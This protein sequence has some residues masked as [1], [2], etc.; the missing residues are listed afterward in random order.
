VAQIVTDINAYITVDAD[1]QTTFNI[2]QFMIA[3]ATRLAAIPDPG[4]NYAYNTPELLR[5]VNV[6]PFADKLLADLKGIAE[7]NVGTKDI[8]ALLLDLEA[9]AAAVTK[10]YDA[11]Y[12]EKSA[13][14]AIASLSSGPIHKNMPDAEDTTKETRYYRTTFVDDW[15]VESAPSEV[16]AAVEVGPKDTVTVTVGTVPTGRDITH[17]R[18]Y[19]SNS[20]NETA[21]FQ[22][23][24][25]P[26]DDNG[27][28]IAS[29][30]VT[31]NVKNSALQEICPTTIWD[32][33]PT[34]LQGLV[35]MANGIHL[36][37]FGNTLCPSI[38]YK[39][40]AYPEDYR[41]TV[42]WPIVGLAAWGQSAFVGTRGKPY[43]VHGTDA[44]SL[45][46]EVLDS[47]QACVSARSICATE[48]GVVYASPDGLCLATPVGVEVIT[49]GHFTREEWQALGP[50]NLIAREHDGS[51]YMVLPNTVL[52]ASQALLLWL[53]ASD[54]S[55]ITEVGGKVSAWNDKSG[56]ARHAV[57]STDSSRGT[58]ETNRFASGAIQFDG[59]EG[60]TFTSLNVTVGCTIFIV[61]HWTQ[62]A[63]VYTSM[64][65]AGG[66][67]IQTTGT[68]YVG[69]VS[70]PSSYGTQTLS[71]SPN[72]VE[73]ATN[74]I[75]TQKAV[76]EYLTSATLEQSRVFLN[77]VDITSSR[78]GTSWNITI[79]RVAGQTFYASN[80][81]QFAEI[82]VYDG[83]L[84]DAERSDIRA[85]LS[86]KWG[87]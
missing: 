73:S 69:I 58:R 42:E 75:G 23:V 87:I 46:A 9:K 70:S 50:E 3:A 51:I 45:S 64:V 82:L 74:A 86:A 10:Y 85:Q 61:G 1:G 65:M 83:I 2:A 29:T 71:D 28:P 32:E 27:V 76:F 54:T 17:W 53:D 68:D 81:N 25:Y 67:N 30:T 37:F 20:G 59:A 55:T 35:G 14:L 36:G 33:P 8:P 49:A 60:M 39:P 4:F 78:T 26:T 18:G 72:F 77:G 19:R 6:R 48:A 13:D 11:A 41:L 7:A 80:G 34:N 52:N 79:D 62:A 21:D 57:Q 40:W 5:S 22:Y 84:T 24:P 47:N 66:S 12:S 56:N 44:A 38:N 31:D 16:S 43:F 15:S 63:G